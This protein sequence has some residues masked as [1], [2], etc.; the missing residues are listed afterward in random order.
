MRIVKQLLQFLNETLDHEK[1]QQIENCHQLALN[2]EPVERLP[3]VVSFPYPKSGEIQ[4]FPHGEVFDDP[5]KMLF[6]ELVHAFGTSIFLYSELLD[7]LSFTIRANFGTVV[8]ASLF[9]GLV[10]QRGDN[11]PWIRH[12]ETLDGFKSIFDKDPFDFSQGIC[13][14][15]IER[16]LFYLDVFLTIPTFKSVSKSF[17]RFFSGHLI[18]PNF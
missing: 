18:C 7:D 9:G 13:P 2:W 15:I 16:Y 4:P 12:F 3:L 1:H 17:C 10:E 5:G 11:P 6:N 14:Q 8:I